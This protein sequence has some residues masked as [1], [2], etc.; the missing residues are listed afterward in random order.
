MSAQANAMINPPGGAA[1][2]DLVTRAGLG[3]RDAFATLYNEYRAGV[4][5]FLARRTKDRGLAEDL[6]SETFVRALRRI[7]VFAER[8]ASG[9][10]SAWLITIARNLHLDHLRSARFQREVLVAEMF[11]DSVGREPSAEAT[12]LHG[13][14]FAEMV[15]DLKAAMDELTPYQRDCVRLRFLEGLSGPETAARLGKTGMAVK[16]AQHRAMSTMKHT[17]RSRAAVRQQDGAAA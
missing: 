2:T 14:D 12:A 11:D 4:Y 1:V 15:G 10:F 5:R 7:D 3:D 6:T 9:G 8:S 16:M 17:I 13:L